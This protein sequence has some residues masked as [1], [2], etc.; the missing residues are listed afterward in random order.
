MQ[1]KIQAMDNTDAL[2]R[3]ERQLD[4]MEALQELNTGTS[5]FNWRSGGIFDWI[6]IL[7]KI[8]DEKIVK[9]CGTDTALYLDFLLYASKFFGY[10]S[11]ISVFIVLP[12][13]FSG[14]PSP[15]NDFRLHPNQVP[16]QAFTILNISASTAKTTAAFLYAMMIIPPMGFR[17]ILRYL[18]RY[19]FQT[20]KDEQFDDSSSH[21]ALDIFEEDE[22][23]KS[24]SVLVDVKKLRQEPRLLEDQDM[25]QKL[26]SDLEI[27][28]HAIMLSNLPKDIPRLQLEETLKNVFDQIIHD[29]GLAGANGQSQVV[30]VVAI[31]KLNPLIALYRK[32]EYFDDCYKKLDGQEGDAIEEYFNESSDGRMQYVEGREPR[33]TITVKTSMC[34]K[35]TRED[36]YEY[37]QEEI[38]KL[39]SKINVSL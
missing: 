33:P 38:A 3:L 2:L 36:A 16:M 4:I 1:E 21:S 23:K 34:A 19:Q 7:S 29:E 24:E 27:A 35:R 17:L 37:Y 9:V 10:L 32:L 28:Q 15:T 13:Y 5:I 25:Y 20:E 22:R 12:I 11:L 18:N 8:D 14:E 39:K 26:Y 30:K 31:S 6:V